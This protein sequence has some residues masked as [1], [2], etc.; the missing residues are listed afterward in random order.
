VQTPIDVA[1]EMARAFESL[2]IGYFLGGSFASSMQG[3]PRATNDIDFV[4]DLP[5]SKVESLAQTLGPDFEVDVESLLEA[6]RQRR[7]W[8]IFHLPTAVKIDLFILQHAPFDLS[9]FSRRRAVE[10]GP[11]MSLVVKSP[12]DTVLRKLL[13]FQAGGGVSERQWR[14]VVQVLRVSG[15][16]MDETYLVQWAERLGV[17]ELLARARTEAGRGR[18]D[19]PS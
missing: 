13:W 3:E 14:D 9:E 11:A 15:A 10:L 4:V 1:L 12:E 8:N 16:A 19:R 7:T 2:G 17:T 5:P 18:A 6:A